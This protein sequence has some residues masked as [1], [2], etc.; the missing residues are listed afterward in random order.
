MH[1]VDPP[2]VP[3][4]RSESSSKSGYRHEMTIDQHEDLLEFLLTLKGYV[5]LSGYKNEMYGRILKDWKLV[6]K[7]AFADG[8][9]LRT[10]CLWLS[11]NCKIYDL[12]A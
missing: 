2:Y 9:R 11:P 4:T 7:Y 3:A 10:E 8:A 12:L 1:Y 6:E 5:I